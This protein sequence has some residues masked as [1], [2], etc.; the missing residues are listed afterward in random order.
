MELSIERSCRICLIEGT[1]LFDLFDEH[2]GRPIG[3]LIREISGVEISVD[4]ALSKKICPT[5]FEKSVDFQAFRQLCIDS[6][7]TVRYNLL[8]DDTCDAQSG[9]QDTVLEDQEYFME[10]DEAV[11]P[12][13]G[14]DQE[15]T[16]HE[17]LEYNDLFIN[18][19]NDGDLSDG[20]EPEA[21]QIERVDS[22]MVA[23]AAVLI[24]DDEEITKKMREAHLAKEQQKK[25][26]CEF[27]DKKFK[28]PSKGLRN[29]NVF[30]SC[31]H[32]NIS[33]RFS[34]SPQ[35]SSA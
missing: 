15:Y 9:T 24:P 17:Q 34:D 25:Y 20:I 23:S 4:D 2:E 26:S 33:S 32:L 5:C 16:Q 12:E 1:S 35:A 7:E 6:D 30:H 22:K 13:T 18:E 27:C 19:P 14:A 31:L 11:H 21:I 28:F 3:D 10:E 29:L 8:L